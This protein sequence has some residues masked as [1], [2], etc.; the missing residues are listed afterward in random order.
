MSRFWIR[1]EVA[2]AV[3]LSGASLAL[4]N[5][6]EG[7]TEA[8][9][10]VELA[11]GEPGTLM[12]LNVREGDR[13]QKGQLVGSLD[14]DALLVAKQIAKLNMESHGRLDAAAAERDLRK[15]RLEK[16][17]ALRIK[18]HASQEEV[19]RASA[20]ADIA[21]ANVLS[22][23]EQL[24]VDALEFKR[25]EALIE[26]RTLRSPMDGVVTRIFHEEREY[27]MSSAPT[28]MTVVQLDPLRVVF[29]IPLAQST[30]LAAGQ[31]VPLTLPD[32][33]LTTEGTI[34]F[35]SPVVDAESGTVRVKVLLP[36]AKGEY[37]AGIRCGFGKDMPAPPEASA[38]AAQ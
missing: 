6:I 29:S 32:L 31:T 33:N 1:I 12:S 9:R 11:P 3:A 38:D 18:G 8:F 30:K 27:V 20:D 23:R 10:Q 13:V 4:G 17:Q 16:L 26:R 35:V 34:E 25:A 37:R 24:A 5:P 2:F 7:F 14:C 28:V 22:A 15:S 21:E 19:N 36:N